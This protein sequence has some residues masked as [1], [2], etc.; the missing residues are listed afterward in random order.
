MIFLGWGQ[1]QFVGGAHRELRL[2]ERPNTQHGLEDLQTVVHSSLEDFGLVGCPLAW[3]GSS[4]VLELN[5]VI[6]QFARGSK[7]QVSHNKFCPSENV[8]LSSLTTSSAGCS[9]K[10]VIF[11]LFDKY[12]GI[13]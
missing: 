1:T 5:V 9:L 10:P 7:I 13:S 2:S 6:P 8:F 12:T 4:F 3:R 11:A